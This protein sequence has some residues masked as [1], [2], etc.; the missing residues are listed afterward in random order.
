MNDFQPKL[1]TLSDEDVDQYLKA[2]VEPE[3]LK[4]SETAKE[5]PV[6]APKAK[7]KVEEEKETV[8]E[9]TTYNKDKQEIKTLTED[10]EKNLLEGVAEETEKKSLTKEDVKNSIGYKDMVSL[11]IEEDEWEKEVVMEDGTKIDLTQVPEEEFTPEVYANLVKYQNSLKVNR[12]LQEE[13]AKYG[14]DGIQLFDYLRNGGKIEQIAEYYQQS[15]D[16]D[17]IDVKTVDGSVE[18]IK[19][20]YERSGEDKEW[21]DDYISTLKDKGDESLIIKDGERKK[22]KILEA[23]EEEKKE[24]LA[25]QAEVAEQNKIAEQ[26][27]NTQVREAIHTDEIPDRDKKEYEKYYFEHKFPH[28]RNP[29]AKVNQFFLDFE[30]IQNDPKKFFKL[31]K[32]VKNFDKFEDKAKVKAEE[33]KN[34]HTF[35]RRNQSSLTTPSSQTPEYQSNKSNGVFDI[36]KFN[37]LIKN[38]T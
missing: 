19:E 29:N 3:D 13:K 16:I 24:V 20:Y 11:F 32:I 30:K 15:R 38:K 23:I 4:G 33:K 34:Q 28:P 22:S 5:A 35:L 36:E 2:S 25:R 8:E 21:I 26:R 17:S 10:D 18:A 12:A 6:K 7:E 31:Q 9:D 14:E 37:K 27:Y 1:R